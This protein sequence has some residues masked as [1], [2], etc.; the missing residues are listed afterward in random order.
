FCPAITFERLSQY[1]FRGLRVRVLL[2]YLLERKGE[3]KCSAPSAQRVP[4]DL[5]PWF[6][7]TC[8]CLLFAMRVVRRDERSAIITKI[9]DKIFLA[10]P[11]ELTHDG[12]EAITARCQIESSWVVVL[13]LNIDAGWIFTNGSD[14]VAEDNLDLVRDSIEDGLC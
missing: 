10:T 4:A 5:S 13:E 8:I 2:K 11:H 1:G 3:E 7:V 14:A 9:I 6:C 12:M